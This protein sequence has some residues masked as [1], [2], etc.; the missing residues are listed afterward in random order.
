MKLTSR[1]LTVAVAGCLL[2]ACG[3][4]GKPGGQTLATVN[5]DQIT[6][7]QLNFELANQPELASIPA[8]KAQQIA[9]ERM[10]GQTLLVQK[11][12]EVELDRDPQ[13]MQAI[14][15]ANNLIYA[16][17]YVDRIT[18]SIAAPTDAEIRDYF[19]E[20]PEL[21][22]Q[23]KVY[24]LQQIMIASAMT[25]EQ[26]SERLA[27][28]SG[29]ADLTAKLKQDNIQV[30]YM[31]DSKS[32]DQLPMELLPK[33]AEMKP[34]DTKVLM[35]PQGTLIVHLIN[36][37]PAPVSE[38]EARPMIER[39]LTSMKKQQFVTSEI[40]RLR[41]SGEV[42]MLGKSAKPEDGKAK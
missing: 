15:R 39:F 16:Q 38:T 2:V 12:K 4:S 13:V 36:A 42:E 27:K 1:I 11:A 21:F 29:L 23:R 14:T 32:A 35:G 19:N 33:L 3:D 30:Q 28:A 18:K 9:L 31:A 40:E 25:K 17:A 10:I 22:T 34:G 26:L 6:V 41:K 20:H 7:H 24:D 37:R 8:D 5:G